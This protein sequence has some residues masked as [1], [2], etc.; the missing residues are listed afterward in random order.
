[1]SSLEERIADRQRLRDKA[2]EKA[3]QCSEQIKRLEKQKHEKER[4]ERT[5]ALILCGA[6]IAQV[7]Q[8]ILTEEEMKR[9]SDFLKKK[10]ETGEFGMDCFEKYAGAIEGEKRTKNEGLTEWGK[11]E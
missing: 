3:Q 11:I 9:V 6:Y 5:H 7:F 10:I 4:K 1:M 8:R 2:L